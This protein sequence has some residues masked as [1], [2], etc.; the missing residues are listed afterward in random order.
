MIGTVFV[1]TK[2]TKYNK[3]GIWITWENQIRNHGLSAAFGYKFIE[4]DIKK[5]RLQRYL[6]SISQTIGWIIKERPD[7]VV[8]QNPSIVLSL[9]VVFVRPL[10]KYFLVIDAHNSGLF[11]ADS[12]SAFLNSLARFLQK[13]AGITIVTNQDLAEHVSR[14]GGNPCVLPDRLPVVPKPLNK[15]ILDGSINVVFVCSYHADE[16]YLEVFEAAKLIPKNVVLYVTGNHKNRFDVQSLSQ[17]VKL[18]GFL[19]T[20]EYWSLLHSANIIID[21]T[22]RENC[23]VCGAYEAVA[24]SKPMILSNTDATK[25]YFTSGCVYTGPTA[26][27][28]ASSILEITTNLKRFQDEIAILQVNLEI[29]W[30]KKLEHCIGCINKNV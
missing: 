20:D 7:V 2:I 8:A 21:L 16:P 10:F 23:L 11:P 4:L 19:P 14:N 15:K 1:E 26:A 9:L 12:R 29:E 28:I 24:L 27:E 5:P 3:R 6:L 17:N 30:Q 25:K 18:T 13:Q 22:T